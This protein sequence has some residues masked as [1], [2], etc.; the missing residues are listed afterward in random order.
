MGGFGLCSLCFRAQ[1]VVV[2]LSFLS[3]EAVS[4]IAR[5]GKPSCGLRAAPAIPCELLSGVVR[6]PYYT[7]LLLE[8]SNRC[9]FFRRP[10]PLSVLQILFLCCLHSVWARPHN[11]LASGGVTASIVGVAP[12]NKVTSSVPVRP[13]LEHNNQFEQEVALFGAFT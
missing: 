9:H 12:V 11:S 2:G 7:L 5:K 1:A 8:A 3:G 10:S 6:A 13:C 4:G